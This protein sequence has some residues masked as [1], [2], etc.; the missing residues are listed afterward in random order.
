MLALPLKMSQ[1]H[2]NHVVHV[3]QD[4]SDEVGCIS[5]VVP[6]LEKLYDVV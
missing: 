5:A 4:F 3:V 6:V 2:S 1:S